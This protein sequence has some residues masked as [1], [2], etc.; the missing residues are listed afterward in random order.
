MQYKSRTDKLTNKIFNELWQNCIDIKA[1]LNKFN[2]KNKR[3][4]ASILGKYIKFVTGN[5][6]E[7]DLSNI[8]NNLDKLYENQNSEL[9]QINKL[10]TFANHLSQRYATDLK[11]LE[12]NFNNTKTFINDLKSIEDTR[13]I[14]QNEIYLSSRLLNKLQL[15]ERTI[16]LAWKEITN[17]ELITVDELLTIHKY[18]S[19]NYNEQ[20]LLPIDDHHIFKILQSSKLIVI[21]TKETI[22]FLLKIPITKPIDAS[23]YQIYPIPNQQDVTLIPPK[24]FL[25]KIDQQEFWTDEP[26]IRYNT[27]NLC[28]QPPTQENCSLNT[29]SKCATTK[30]VNNY[31][32]VYQL[33][34]RQ[35]LTLFKEKQEVTEDCHGQLT[36]KWIKGTNLISSNCRIIIETAIYDNT[37][38]TYEVP[39]D[40]IPEN[41]LTNYHQKSSLHLKHLTDPK[42]LQEEAEELEEEP[43]H[44]KLIVHVAH[45]SLTLLF[46]IIFI[47]IFILIIKHN[48]RIHDLFCKPR[49]IIKIQAINPKNLEQE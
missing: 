21:G 30:I 37:L 6:D 36:Q 38:P 45:Y 4:L 16:T 9:K 32:I 23:Y 1:L 11:L 43:L 31:K 42:K 29:F 5:L 10:T 15:I 20:Q 26:C 13:M 25:I 28:L 18:L 2:F 49:Q 46:L 8:N 3:A 24:K 33:R 17:I 44:L 34:N 48:K 41:N 12:T 19:Q 39:L 35:I 47:I 40:K 22:T 27:I 14:L 7:D